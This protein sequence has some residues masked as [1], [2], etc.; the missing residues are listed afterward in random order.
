MEPVYI[1][2]VIANSSLFFISG[3]LFGQA[4]AQNTKYG[5]DIYPTVDEETMEESILYAITKET[6]HDI[7]TG[8]C[9]TIVCNVRK[10]LR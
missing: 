4:H 3:W 6:I 5:I 8:K 2:L 9:K 10:K 1:L 7:H